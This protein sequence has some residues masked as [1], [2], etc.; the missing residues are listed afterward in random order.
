MAIKNR[1]EGIERYGEH[2]KSAEK[3][4]EGKIDKKADPKH[5]FETVERL[6]SG[7]MENKANSEYKARNME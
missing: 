1:E 2:W 4:F 3:F 5:Y 7:R 6:A